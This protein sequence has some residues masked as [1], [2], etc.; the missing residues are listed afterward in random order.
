[1]DRF[2]S[3]KIDGSPLGLKSQEAQRAFRVRSR[4]DSGVVILQAPEKDSPQRHG[5]TSGRMNRWCDGRSLPGRNG[6]N[7]ACIRARPAGLPGFLNRAAAF[8]TSC[9]NPAGV[10]PN[11]QNGLKSGDVTSL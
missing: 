10:G 11:F 4:V 8:L 2:A 5:D 3:R 6:R 9:G 7:F 1:M